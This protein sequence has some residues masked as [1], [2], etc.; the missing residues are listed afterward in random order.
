MIE[1][2][3]IVTELLQIYPGRKSDDYP[4]S[5]Q[6]GEIPLCPQICSSLMSAFRPVIAVLDV[7]AGVWIF[8]LYGFQL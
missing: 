2:I 6:I 1:S 3:T 5:W 4:P 8:K 7:L